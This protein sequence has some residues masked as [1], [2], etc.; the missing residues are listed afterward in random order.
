MGSGTDRRYDLND[1]NDF[2]DLNDRPGITPRSGSGAMRGIVM[3]LAASLLVTANDALV[4]LALGAAGSA[5]V[6]FFRGLFALLALLIYAAISGQFGCLLPRC[7]RLSVGLAGLAV[8]SL[9]LFTYALNFMTLAA[10]VMLAY[11]SPIFVAL[12]APLMLG[13]TI[14]RHQWLAVIISFIGAVQNFILNGGML[15]VDI[16]PVTTG[17]AARMT[18]AFIAGKLPISVSVMHS[19]REM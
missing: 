7:W 10:A 14:G 1:L 6:L 5:E 11:L 18:E 12:L 13:E 2:N 9:F 17:N 3:M 19:P 8:L 15:S 16:S 4:K